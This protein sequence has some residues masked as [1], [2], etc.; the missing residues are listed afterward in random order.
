MKIRFPETQILIFN[1]F[2][3]SP[4]KVRKFEKNPEVRKFEKKVHKFEKKT[5]KFTSSSPPECKLK[6]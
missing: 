4:E 1:Y 2:L 5:L 3:E 6:L